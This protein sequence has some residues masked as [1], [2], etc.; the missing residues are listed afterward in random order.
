MPVQHGGSSSSAGPTVAPRPATTQ[1]AAD[2]LR[3][4][5]ELAV[6]ESPRTPRRTPE[7]ASVSAGSPKR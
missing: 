7:P 4:A 2:E 5:A 1:R 6:P 3:Q